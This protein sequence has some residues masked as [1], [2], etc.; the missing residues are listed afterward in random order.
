MVSESEQYQQRVYRDETKIKS[1][2]DFTKVRPVHKWG[3]SVSEYASIKVSQKKC[4]HQG[5]WCG[6]SETEVMVP[7]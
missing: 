7:K 6:A 3:K 5:V 2:S 1:K 4:E